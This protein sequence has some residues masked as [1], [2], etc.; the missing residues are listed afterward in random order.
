MDYDT[1]EKSMAKL[2]RHLRNV[3]EEYYR[4][5]SEYIT[6]VLEALEL[7]DTIKNYERRNSTG[8]EY[9][10]TIRPDR[11]GKL[12]SIFDTLEFFWKC[13]IRKQVEKGFAILLGIMSVAILLAEATLLPSIDLSLFSILIKSVRTQELLV[14]AFS[15]V[16]L[17]YMCICTYYYLF[18]IGILMFHSLMPRQTSSVNL[19]MICSMVAR[20]VPPISYNFLNLI[21]QGPLYLSTMFVMSYGIGFA[22]LSAT[23]VHVLLFHGSNILQLSKSAFQGKKIDIHTKIMRKKL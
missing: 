14:Q 5:K 8:W 20:Y 12:G 19:L 2:R 4:Y 1:D 7:E 15:F 11:T 23:L 18:K 13:V 17:M 16:P 6:Y 3:C 10:S 22:C 21:R 9:N